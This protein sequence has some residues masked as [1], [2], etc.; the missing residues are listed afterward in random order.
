M[1]GVALYLSIVFYRFSIIYL[2]FSRC[3]GKAVKQQIGFHSHL[4]FVT[5]IHAVE[6]ATPSRVK[7]SALVATAVA[8]YP[9]HRKSYAVKTQSRCVNPT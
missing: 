8:K 4:V 7:G 1:C 6:G 9:T 5:P 3:G 2:F